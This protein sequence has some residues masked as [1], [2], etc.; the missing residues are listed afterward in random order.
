MLLL[1]AMGGLAMA[2]GI[3]SAVTHEIEVGRVSTLIQ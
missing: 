1:K 3:V 2:A